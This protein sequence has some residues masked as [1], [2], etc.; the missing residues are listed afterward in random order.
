MQFYYDK[1]NDAMEYAHEQR[2]RD[3]L[4]VNILDRSVRLWS[5]IFI[6]R[7]IKNIYL[8]DPH[9]RRLTLSPINSTIDN[10][11]RYVKLI[12]QF[13][14]KYI[15]GN[16][17]LLYHLACYTQDTNIKNVKFK[18]FLSYF[19][20]LFLY[21]KELIEKQFGCEI[22]NQ[23]SCEERV[24]SAIE[25]S[26][27]QGMHIEM[28]KGILEIIGENGKILPKG[29]TGKIIATGLY[30][31]TMP[32]IRYDT[33]DIGSVSENACSCGRG[34]PLLKSLN[35]RVNDFL[36]FNGKYIYAST[37]SVILWEFKN[38]KECQFIQENEDE[39]KINIVKR[40]KYTEKDTQDLIKML[41][42]MIGQ[43][44]NIKIEFFDYIPRT[45]MGKFPFIVSKIKPNG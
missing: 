11:G 6:E 34:L 36:K 3:W 40:E 8:Y 12:K 45:K 43:K 21:Q 44:L 15:V 27:H 42:K 29:D 31:Y 28:E 20:N 5:R 30:N 9:L 4:S 16:P 26:K 39:I 35:G 7:E 2:Y 14:P 1:R 19:E 24:V 37:L 41:Q 32:L 17:S 13:N 10:L 25:C 18:C 33:G 38:I 23:Y 22:F